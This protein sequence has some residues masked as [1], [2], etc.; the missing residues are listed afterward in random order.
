MKVW[1]QA[2]IST[3]TVWLYLRRDWVRDWRL[4]YTFICYVCDCVHHC[5]RSRI[6][7]YVHKHTYTF[8]C[9]YGDFQSC[10]NMSCIFLYINMYRTAY[11]IYLT[12][13]KRKHVVFSPVAPKTHW[14][15]ERMWNVVISVI[16]SMFV[17]VFEERMRECVCAYNTKHI[18]N[19][20]LS[21]T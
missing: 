12:V 10:W 6:G 7:I 18:I 15:I 16:C 21:S 11:A 8:I 9:G 14:L 13:W 4:S 1:M 20:Y 3:E 5:M 2:E 17:C 19:R